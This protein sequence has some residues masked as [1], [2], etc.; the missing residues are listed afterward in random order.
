MDAAAA[1]AGLP[2]LGLIT[3]PTPLEDAPG[4]AARLGVTTLRLK[5]DDLYPALGGGTKVRKLDLLLAQEPLA[6]AA[7][8]VVAGAA[9]SGQVAAMVAAGR[10]LGRPVHAHLFRTPLGPH[11]LENLAWTASW[12]A[13]I[14]G[15]GGRVDLA[16]RAPRVVLGV[17]VKVAG[18]AGHAGQVVPVG[19]TSPR[20]M[21]GLVMAGIELAGQLSGQ[22]GPV[23]DAVYVACGSGGTA[24]G[25]AVG[26]A[27]A[28][29]DVPVRAVMV[30]E[31]VY[32]LDMRLGWLVQQAEQALRE[33]G[34]SPR[35]ARLELI[36]GHV[37]PGYAE[38][39]ETSLLGASWLLE[40]GIAGEPVYT[41][42]ALAALAEDAQAGRTRHPLFW[43][44]VRRAGLEPREGWRDRLPPL[45]R[46]LAHDAGAGGSV[47]AGPRSPQRRRLMAGLAAA[48][49][50]VGVVRLTGY[51]GEGGEV[52][53]AAEVA[54]VRAAGEALFPDASATDLD[55]L[56][57]RVDR[58]LLTFPVSLRAE[59]HAL[60]FAVEQT[61]P[62]SVGLVRFTSLSPA[63]R[64]LALQ[65]VASLGGPGLLIARSMRDLVLVAWY[66]GEGA[67]PEIGY[68]GPM[69]EAGPRP[70]GAGA[71]VY[72]ALRAPAGWVPF[73]GAA[74]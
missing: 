24:A 39:S 21:L 19:A 18:Y 62:F 66:Q 20:S 59:V 6:S 71:S 52:L 64:L 31:R 63:D 2:R 10:A 17:P 53:L 13:S 16:V 67:W 48:A 27:L 14:T 11:G 35:P 47:G 30:V 44:T 43:V 8:W 26:L 41:G 55:A 69:V 61:L 28:G 70:G 49:A 3:G 45:L 36:R 12:A 58:Y 29:L 56:A 23:P 57:G 32:S 73:G 40:E 33:L 60:F 37:G 4:L 34:L 65:R 51:E 68:E 15:Y 46:D 7:V 38:A 25:L 50:L 5:R 74:P 42:K 54:V 9:G 72:D 22:P 1:F